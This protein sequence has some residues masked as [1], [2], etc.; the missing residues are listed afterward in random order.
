MQEET[1]LNGVDTTYKDKD[2]KSIKVHSYVQDEDGRMYY[3]NSH[4]QAVPEGDDAPAVEL[5]RL[6]ETGAVRVMTAAEVLER[7]RQEGRRRRGGRRTRVSV[8]ASADKS[9]EAV[10]EE[11]P[12][13]E[14]LSP[15]SMHMVLTA[16]PDDVL[17]QELRRRGYYLTA[18]KPALVQL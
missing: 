1:K 16:I 3:I 11:A 10:R 15:V 9:P 8:E 4:C 6:V 14:E 13:Q 17:A 7:P 18:V 5:S 12:P 2:G